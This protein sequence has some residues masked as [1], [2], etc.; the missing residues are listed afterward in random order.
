MTVIDSYWQLITVLSGRSWAKNSSFTR[1]RSHKVCFIDVV[2]PMAAMIGALMDSCPEKK[3]GRDP[4]ISTEIQGFKGIDHLMFWKWLRKF[5]RL[6]SVARSAN[7]FGPEISRIRSMRSEKIN[8][9]FWPQM[10]F[11]IDLKNKGWPT[12][13]CI[14]FCGFW[15]LLER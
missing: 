5:C 11:R 12:N 3:I 1:L 2:F 6:L 14:Y 8:E 7:A 13:L 9:D 10:I 15:K 4:A